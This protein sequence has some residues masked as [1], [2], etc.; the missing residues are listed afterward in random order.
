MR[1]SD[2]LIDEL[3]DLGHSLTVPAPADQRG[4]VRAR[5]V[6]PAPRRSRLRVLLAA[7][8]AAL[9][10][11]VALVAPARAAV[12]EVIGDLLRVAGIEV[13]R[14]P[15]T[16]SLPADPSPL[17][18]AR[19]ADLVE[20]ERAAGFPVLV[21]QLLGPPEGVQLAD[22]DAAGRPRVVT[23]LYR[24]GTVRFDQFA[25]NLDPLFRKTAPN[26]RWVQL[27]GVPDGAI[28]LPEP[29]PLAYQ[30]RDGRPHRESARLAGPTLI[31]DTTEAVTYRL[32][33]LTTLEQAREVAQSVR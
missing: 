3:R 1:E 27:A 7:A 25:G 4:A 2:D 18:S 13:R 21:P 33:G 16:G 19:T 15:P 10:A 26:A 11:S 24:G 20:A 9:I 17:P 6:R 22:V 31:W 29:H 30:G 23:L 14:E 8:V 28:W 5:L 12:V 32:E